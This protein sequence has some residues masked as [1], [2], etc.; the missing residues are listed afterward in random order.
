MV[1]LSRNFTRNFNTLEIHQRIVVDENQ[2]PVA[3]QILFDE[4]QQI[5]EVIENFG[6]TKLMLETEDDERLSGDAAKDFYESLK[7]GD[8]VHIR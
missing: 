3:V 2:K 7:A 8:E 1:L 5:E 6:L 4:F